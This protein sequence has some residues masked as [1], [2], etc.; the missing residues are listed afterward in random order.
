MRTHQVDNELILVAP[1]MEYEQQALNLIDEI[2][3]TDTDT[4]FKFAG[5][6]HLQDYHNDYRE[7]L[8]RLKNKLSEETVPAGHVTAN[9]FFAVRKRDNKVV[10]IIDIRHKLNDYLLKYAGHIG[11]S[12]LPSER[13]KGYGYQQ[14]VLALEFCKTLGIKRVLIT[15][16]D[17]NVASYKTIEKAG[18]VLEN[19]IVNPESDALERRY[20]IDNE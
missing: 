7:W 10:G 9:T 13:R 15:C 5:C 16:N 17:Y 4:N 8:I 14:L 3:T 12:V 1:S 18:G 20:W 2:S 11:Y 19:K 6:A